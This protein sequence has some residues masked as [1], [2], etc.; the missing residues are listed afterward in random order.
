MDVLIHDGDTVLTSSGCP[1]YISGIDE[2]LQRVR[3]LAL[4]RRGTFIYDR[5]L[6]TDYAALRDGEQMTASL[7]M[8]LK[9]AAA[10]MSGADVEVLSS[11]AAALT[12]TV[13]VKYNEE[14]RITE[15][16]ISGILR[17]HP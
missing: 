11:D 5:A 13:R 7:D 12:A 2:A 9:E 14:E 17:N 3:M 6:G 4:T 1:V 15:V 8:L 16:D 10:S